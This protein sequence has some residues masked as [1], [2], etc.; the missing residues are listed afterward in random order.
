MR[1]S[2]NRWEQLV[3]WR[4]LDCQWIL[5]AYTIALA[6]SLIALSATAAETRRLSGTY[7]LSSA[8]I[9]DPAPGE[10]PRTH[11]RLHL[12]G[13]AANDLYRALPSNPK[14]DECFDDGSLTK[15]EGEIMCTRHPKGSHECWLGVEL[16]TGKVV[17][18]SVC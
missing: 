3:K 5:S 12:T 1:A 9:I 2:E 6:A 11:L 13:F 16:K 4:F 7:A 17:A 10:Q 15:R 18:G 8:S 14:R